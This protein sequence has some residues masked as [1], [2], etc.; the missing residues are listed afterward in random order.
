MK[1]NKEVYLTI[2]A[3]NKHFYPKSAKQTTQ[4]SRGNE[5]FE[6]GTSLAAE[7]LKRFKAVLVG[8]C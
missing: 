8:K 5:Y 4:K 1:S 7:S 3:Y 6:L 2:D